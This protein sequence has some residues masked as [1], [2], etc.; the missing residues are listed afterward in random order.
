MDIR[1][2]VRGVDKV[3]AYLKSL[4][5][6]V[7]RV[8]L[9]AIGTYI[10]GD[11]SH[12]LSHPDPYRYVSRKR[13]YGKTFQSDAQRRYVMAKIRSGEITPGTPNRT[14]MST[15]AWTMRETNNGY[16]LSLRNPT[17]GAYYTR[18]DSGQ[19]RQPGLV[20]WRKVSKVVADN[21]KGALRHANAAVAAFLRGK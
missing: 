21:I 7:L 6:G 10:I 13:A 2:N 8:A 1:F 17:P 16:G 19:A 15:S 20:G 14:G 5:R 9:K 3:Q 4:P 12:G 11:G 18:S